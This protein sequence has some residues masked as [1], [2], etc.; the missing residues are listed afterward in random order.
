MD[1]KKYR[2]SVYK[3]IGAAMEVH[4]VLKYGL[5]ESVYQE[6]LSYELNKRGIFCETEVN[7]DVFYKDV[8][9]KKKFRMDIIVGDVIL[10]LK[11]STKIISAH[12]AQLCNYLRLT[13]KP[14]GII[15]NFG[16]ETLQGERWVYDKVSN[17]CQLVD[18]NMEPIYSSVDFIQLFIY[19]FIITIYKKLFIS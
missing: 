16:S 7:V 3:I 10:E 2:D 11:S 1:A 8:L 14:I 4:S 15:L 12:R 9:L 19:Q 5:L 18:K 13:Q 6:A 17:D